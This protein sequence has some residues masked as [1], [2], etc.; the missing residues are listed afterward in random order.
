M[1]I[2]FSMYANML[3][4]TELLQLPK[5]TGYGFGLSVIR[6]GTALLPAGLTMMLLSPVSAKITKRYGP[7]ITLITGA[8]F[9]GLGYIF[10]IYIRGSVFELII[11]AIIVSSG[12]AIAY[13]AI[14]SLI[15][16]SVPV[17]ESASANGL[18]SVIR[19]IGTSTA[20][21]VIAAMLS[22]MIMS[23]SGNYFPTNRAFTL[24]FIIAAGAAFLGGAIAIFLPKIRIG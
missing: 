18:N 9:L 21:A 12:T 17:S 5:I 13:G 2:G 7:R 24:I 19:T 4:N 16:R 10:R 1:V 8:C 6:A 20:S 23:V 11:G 3:T 22:G 14:P 15:M